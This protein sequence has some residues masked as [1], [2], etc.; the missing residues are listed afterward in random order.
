[1]ILALGASGPG[2]KS[3]TSP[4]AFLGCARLLTKMQQLDMLNWRAV[5]KK[6]KLSR[7]CDENIIVKL[8]SL[9]TSH[10]TFKH[11]KCKAIWSCVPYLGLQNLPIS[12][13]SKF[14]ARQLFQEMYQH[15]SNQLLFNHYKAEIKCCITNFT[16]LCSRYFNIQIMITELPTD[17]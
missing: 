1:M 15:K 7:N 16:R 12:G 17:C 10:K 4:N 8:L 14:Y 5:H 9:I 13:L 2:F 11:Y 3:R 6:H